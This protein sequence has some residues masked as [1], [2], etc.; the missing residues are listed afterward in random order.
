MRSTTVAFSLVS[1][2]GLCFGV[3]GTAGGAALVKHH[4][5]VPKVED[6]S[7]IFIG[8][9]ASVLCLA[10]VSRLMLCQLRLALYTSGPPKRGF[11]SRR[12]LVSRPP[13][14]LGETFV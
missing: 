4:D 12:W 8:R 7:V 13:A 3:D 1:A 10:S 5:N 9:A 14:G 2:R 11:P 6:L